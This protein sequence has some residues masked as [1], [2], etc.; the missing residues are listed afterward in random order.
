MTAVGSTGRGTIAL[1]TLPDSDPEA[2]RAV[3]T[4]A[5]LGVLLAYNHNAGLAW[6]A[7]LGAEE[8]QQKAAPRSNFAG[9]CL[10][11]KL[12]GLI[13]ICKANRAREKI[14][15]ALADGVAD[16][17]TDIH[18]DA[19]KAGKALR[20]HVIKKFIAKSTIALAKRLGALLQAVNI[21][22]VVDPIELKDFKVET[23][24]RVIRH[25]PPE[26][27]NLLP[28]EV[29]Y[30]R[31]YD[32]FTPVRVNAV[33]VPNIPT[34]ELRK[35]LRAQEL[36]LLKKG[37]KAGGVDDATAAVIA[38]VYEELLQKDPLIEIIAK[39]AESHNERVREIQVG[40]CDLLH[41]YPKKNGPGR[42]GNPNQGYRRG[43]SVLWIYAKRPQGEDD[44]FFV[45]R[46]PRGSD[47][48][49]IV[50]RPD[51]F[52]FHT[53]GEAR[54]LTRTTRDPCAFSAPVSVKP[55]VGA[56][57]F[58]ETG[59]AALPGLPQARSYAQRVF[60]GPPDATVTVT[61]AA[62][63]AQ[64]SHGVPPNTQ[65]VFRNETLHDRDGPY[66]LQGGGGHSNA[67]V[68]VTR[69][70][71]TSWQIEMEAQGYQEP[72]FDPP[73][74]RIFRFWPAT[75]YVNIGLG[76]AQP[77]E[78]SYRLSLRGEAKSLGADWCQMFV[79]L[80]SSSENVSQG[81]PTNISQPNPPI[82]LSKDDPRPTGP[83]SLFIRIYAHGI[84]H[85][86]PFAPS[87]TTCRASGLIQIEAA[88]DEDEE[89][90]EEE[91]PEEDVE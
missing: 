51:N 32:L 4:R 59:P 85:N 27:R 69:V 72:D 64:I 18:K 44:Y 90:P 67:R 28:K 70:S 61:N 52:I 75:A 89:E 81:S 9:T 36:A 11:A 8:E 68:A 48:L 86:G 24:G 46:I 16:F 12:N 15:N 82:T 60:V 76:F 42:D 40:N 55:R 34:E 45:G 83:G 54:E 2:I 26:R 53:E 66:I 91:E 17:L 21:A 77:R 19:P 43:R 49:C 1:D 23:V 73:P 87:T 88:E 71:E 30:S 10:D 74:F 62:A 35:K 47:S 84:G 65:Q 37:L 39:L 29:L 78:N 80:G 31:S 56:R 50:P 20:D 63:D 33:L 38:K 6:K 7:I 14:S 57:R 41:V 79:R 3:V 58:A 22:C 13:R 5:D 25:L